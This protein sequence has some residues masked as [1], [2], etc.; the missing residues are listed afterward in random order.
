MAPL[1]QSSWKRSMAVRTCRRVLLSSSSLLRRT[2]IS[3]Y[4]SAAAARIE[5]IT[6]V[7]SSSISVSPRLLD[8]DTRCTH[9]R[10]DV[11]AVVHAYGR[12]TVD[13]IGDAGLLAL[14]LQAR[15]RRAFA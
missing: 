1:R 3:A 8:H 7:I 15:K 14:E 11:L 5:R 13:E 12:G 6:S 10:T 2:A 9:L 4:G